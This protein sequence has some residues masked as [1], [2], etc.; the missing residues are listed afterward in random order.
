MP[1]G[2]T[3]E[4]SLDPH[5]TLKNPSKS[6]EKHAAAMKDLRDKAPWKGVRVVRGGAEIAWYLPSDGII[7]AKGT[8]VIEASALQVLDFV[9]PKTLAGAQQTF[10]VIYEMTRAVDLEMHGDV[11]W[12]WMHINYGVAG[13]ADREVLYTLRVF[14]APS[15]AIFVFVFPLEKWDKHPPRKDLV[16]AGFYAGSGFII[17]PL[18]D[19][20]CCVTFLSRTSACGRIPL[21]V[22]NYLATSKG[23]LIC[24][25]QSYFRVN[26][27]RMA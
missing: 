22:T 16:R 8:A 15:G 3:D 20:T 18:S 19:T 14:H 1:K 21:W 11:A 26:S 12:L 7:V 23:R 2:K 25:L 10:N 6:D 9:F 27:P 4:Q 5:E 24:Q 17:E 13:I